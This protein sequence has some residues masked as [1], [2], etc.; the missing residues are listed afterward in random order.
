MRQPDGSVQQWDGAESGETP[1]MH[2]NNSMLSFN[3][4]YTSLLNNLTNAGVAAERAA[5]PSER[6]VHRG[7]DGRQSL[8]QLLQQYH[9]VEEK[10]SNGGSDGGLQFASGEQPDARKVAA[11]GD[12]AVAGNQCDHC[13]RR[14]VKCVTVPEHSNCLHC[15]T[16]GI[17]CVFSEMPS[18]RMKK[19]LQQGMQNKRSRSEENGAWIQELLKRAKGSGPSNSES[20]SQFYADL[21]QNLNSTLANT[22]PPPIFSKKN[23]EAAIPAHSASPPS[24][25][26]HYSYGSNLPTADAV[27]RSDSHFN[28]ALAKY[29]RSSFYVGPTSMFDINLVNHMKL[30]KIDQVQLSNT[31]ALRKVAPGVQFVLRA[32]FNHQSYLKNERDVD[33]VEKL[34][35]PHGKILVDIFFKL[36]H[37]YF[38]ILHERVFLEKYS[39]SYRELTAP[40]LA[41]VYSLALQWWDFHPQAVGFQRPDVIDQLNEI[42]L[43]TFF[44]VLERPKLS[45]VQTGLLILQCRSECPNNWILC[46]EVVAL[47]EDLGLGIDCKDWRLPSWE[48]GLRRRLAWA[49]WYQDKWISMLEARYSHLILGRNWLVKMLSDEDFPANSPVISSSQE[50]NNVNVGP[51]KGPPSNIAVLD[52]SPTD[53][54]F[55]NGKLLFRQMV[56]LSIILGEILDTFYTL[57]AISTTT[58]IEQVLKLAK[59]L[60]LKLREWYHSLPSKL[61]MN[62]FQP[63]KFNSNASLTLAYFAAEITL[64]RKIITTL[65]PDSPGDLVQV[66]RTAAKTRLIAAIEFVR[67]LKTEHISAFWYSCTTGNLTLISTF[68]GLLYVTAQTKEDARVF[69]D[70]L[71]N[72]VWILRMASKSYEKAANALERI[73]MLLSQIPG[74]L[75]DE[76]APQQFI[77]PRSQSPYSQQYSTSGSHSGFEA[78]SGQNTASMLNGESNFSEGAFQQLRS[79]PPDVLLTL[80]SIQHNL[81]GVPH[82][83]R[84]NL[85]SAAKSDEELE[86]SPGYSAASTQLQGTETYKGV[87]Q[88]HTHNKPSITSSSSGSIPSGTNGKSSS[89]SSAAFTGDTDSGGRRNASNSNAGAA[90]KPNSALDPGQ[91]AHVGSTSP[92]PSSSMD[93][94]QSKAIQEETSLPK[95]PRKSPTMPGNTS[96]ANSAESA[97]VEH[98]E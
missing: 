31:L 46:S 26:G 77:P 12:E 97:S 50:K 39:K 18:A 54:D 90:F 48:R 58:K 27:G 41:S 91:D 81:P 38:P 55:N 49:V 14:Q 40:I 62:S 85:P 25:P 67:D 63:R 87:Q 6:T 84:G 78:Q 15:E 4:D 10:G 9:A 1:T 96:G 30:D 70:C 98:S 21:L 68:A 11:G 22:P 8:D 20:I 28:A 60:Q 82:D 5:Q 66:C 89:E 56:S 88:S 44:D 34:V 61:S 64:H 92:S 94:P 52:L 86:L 24:G 47:A 69:R 13:R 17:K 51:E 65:Q 80:K 95:S 32:D 42:A 73:Q 19:T 3:D 45:I 75:T 76:V 35:H 71:R 57:G 83:L 33:L 74:L 93:N 43:R 29:P 16:K 72:Y 53:E 36:I 23:H 37:P 7:G 59:P 2:T 79:L